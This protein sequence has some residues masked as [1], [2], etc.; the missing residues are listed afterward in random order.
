M[1]VNIAKLTQGGQVGY[2]RVLG[3]LMAD[4]LLTMA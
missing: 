1:P 3:K 2:P 4:A